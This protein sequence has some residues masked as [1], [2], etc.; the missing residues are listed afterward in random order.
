MA[1]GSEAKQQSLLNSF[2][3]VNHL[4]G[5]RESTRKLG[6]LQR[7]AIDIPG[8]DLFLASSEEKYARERVSMDV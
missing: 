8:Y 1:I 7:H 3:S 5:H 6:F 2:D 4:V